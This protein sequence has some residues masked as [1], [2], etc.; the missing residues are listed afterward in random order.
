[1]HTV[2]GYLSTDSST[3]KYHPWVGRSAVPCSLAAGLLQN[4]PPGPTNPPRGRGPS[5]TRRTAPL[6]PRAWITRV[7]APPPPRT[8]AD[9]CTHPRPLRGMKKPAKQISP[10]PLLSLSPPSKAKRAR[11]EAAKELETE[12]SGLGRRGRGGRGRGPIRPGWW[13]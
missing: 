9:F 13:A 11:E 12:T 8:P 6:G 5:W 4:R 1:V 2:L 10:K 3:Q 7:R